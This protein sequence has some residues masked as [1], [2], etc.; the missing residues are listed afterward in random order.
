MGNLLRDGS[1]LALCPSPE[2]PVETVGKVFDV[3]DRH[4]V[5]PK[6]L[7]Y[8]GTWF[9]PSSEVMAK[10]GSLEREPSAIPQS[11]SIPPG[12]TMVTILS[13]SSI[14]VAPWVVVCAAK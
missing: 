9:G 5:P 13:T 2:L 6:L 4:M 8:G 12:Q 11:P 14:H 10:H 1:M 7:H 3:E